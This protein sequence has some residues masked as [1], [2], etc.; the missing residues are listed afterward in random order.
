MDPRY[1][2]EQVADLVFGE[3]GEVLL[4]AQGRDEDMA[5]EE[6]FE[7]DESEG[8]GSCVEDLPGAST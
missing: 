8:V 3:V 2:E 4:A 7:I 6:R 5:R 1:R